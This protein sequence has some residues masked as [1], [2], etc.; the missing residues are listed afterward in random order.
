MTQIHNILEILE[1]KSSAIDA[2]FEN[3]YSRTLPLFFCSVDIRDSGTKI[4]PVDT[5][6]FPGGFNNINSDEL[7]DV[8]DA[9]E[10]FMKKY[11]VGH[12][13]LL[14]PESHTRNQAYLKNIE[15]LKKILE[16]NNREVIIAPLENIKNNNSVISTDANFTPDTI[17]LNNDLSDGIPQALKGNTMQQIIP[18][19]QY[20][21]SIR[22][23]SSHFKEYKEI[24][25]K[26]CTE[27]RIDPFYLSATFN[28]CNNVNFKTSTGLEGVIKK[29]EAIF[30]TIEEEYKQHNLHEKPYV[31]IKAD[32]GTYGMGI[33]HITRPDEIYSLNKD[34]RKKMHKIKGGTINDRVIIQEG[35][36]TAITYQNN[37]A[38]PLIYLI[39]GNPVKNLLRVNSTRNNIDNL[40]KSGATFVTMNTDS[41]S[42]S[43]IYLLVAKLASLAASK[44]A[45]SR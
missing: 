18:S 22:R 14:I 19:L 44:E 20:A 1:S 30:E 37:V 35:I 36:E 32:S 34:A 28:E 3:E 9:S 7:P 16:S 12:K 11:C 38:E 15:V 6:V 2:W 40:N 45:I 24:L 42:N 4:A 43:P 10:K 41:Y 17:I 25:D 39:G 29:V 33:M 26:F 31:F 5:N 23:K 21:W 13:I 8:I 27:F